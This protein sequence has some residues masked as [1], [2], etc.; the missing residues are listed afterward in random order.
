MEADTEHR[1]RAIRHL[2]RNVG[3]LQG[4]VDDVV[5][6]YFRQCSI[7]VTAA[8]LA[9]MGAT[10]AHIGENPA[11]GRQV[12]ELTAVRNTLA[13]MFTAACTIIPAIGPMTWA[14]RPRAASAEESSGS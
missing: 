12:F 4:S 7:L 5:D 3:A 6:L 11:T 8:D 1:T 14:C 9:R 13:V 2:L 10:L